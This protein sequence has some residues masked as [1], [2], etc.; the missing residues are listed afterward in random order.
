MPALPPRNGPDR[1]RTGAATTVQASVL[2][3]R[4]FRDVPAFMSAALRLQGAFA[5]SP[6]A[7]EMSL[8]ARRYVARSGRCHIG[9]P[10]PICVALSLIPPI[11]T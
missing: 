4:R 6:G 2:R 9:V 3:L 7:I 5:D 8:R 11:S 1:D 10:T